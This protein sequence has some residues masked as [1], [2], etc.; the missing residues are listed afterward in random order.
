MKSFSRRITRASFDL[1]QE[2][3]LAIFKMSLADPS[4]HFKLVW[5]HVNLAE[6]GKAAT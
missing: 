1:S 6:L 3:I 2:P 4:R 5:L